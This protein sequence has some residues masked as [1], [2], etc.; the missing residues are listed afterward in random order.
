MTLK[1]IIPLTSRGVLKIRGADAKPFLQK[2]ITQNIDRLSPTQALYGALLTTEGRYFS[3]FFLLEW[4]GSVYLDVPRHQ[5]MDLAGAFNTYK[6]RMDVSFHDMSETLFVFSIIG[7]GTE[8]LRDFCLVP[9]EGVCRVEE[10][11]FIFVDPR[12]RAL[13]LRAVAHT[14]TSLP[15]LEI[16]RGT[17]EDY[18][19]FRTQLG[20]SEAPHD[21]IQGQS[22]ILEHGFHE[23][24]G[25]SWDKGCYTGQELIARTFHRGQVH[26]RAV[27]LKIEGPVPGHGTQLRHEDQPVGEMLSNCGSLGMA[28]MRVSVA[29]Q[30]E[31]QKIALTVDRSKLWPYL[32]SWMT[33]GMN[34]EEE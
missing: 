29:R 8:E 3:D 32:L 25:I 16:P 10:E 33:V 17:E 27:P 2:L 7:E 5:L 23:L 28:L 11:S 13:G 21:L 20:I 30:C 34:A 9:V 18:Q 14:Q 12:L 31:Q 22:I 24:N 1:R 4:E 19:F 6:M 26:K 15:I